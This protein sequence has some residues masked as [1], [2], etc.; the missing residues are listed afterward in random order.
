MFPLLLDCE[1]DLHNA[2]GA[3]SN[4]DQVILTGDIFWGEDSVIRIELI[5]HNVLSQHGIV[6]CKCYNPEE[7][8]IL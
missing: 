7:A 3:D 2:S 5:K 4:S 1:V 8:N 6:H